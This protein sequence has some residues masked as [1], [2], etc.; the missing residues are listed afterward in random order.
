MSAAD[1]VE[2]LRQ[3]H[4]GHRSR[5]RAEARAELVGACHALG[6]LAAE[7]SASAYVPPA[8]LAK[9]DAAVTGITRLL[10]E[11]RAPECSRTA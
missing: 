2:F 1:Q 8:D 10:T 11:L 3:L 6:E 9:V 7:W 5:S 4:R